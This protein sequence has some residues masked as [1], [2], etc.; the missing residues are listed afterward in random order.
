MAQ[1]QQNWSHSTAS[2]SLTVGGN[3]PPQV[4][5]NAQ[6]QSQPQQSQVTQQQQMAVSSAT[7][8]FGLPSS[9]FHSAAGGKP[10]STQPPGQHPGQ[11]GFRMSNNGLVDMPMQRS[12][13]EA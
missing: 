10:V 11:N 13:F 9:V 5:M 7:G 8:P 3:G 6:P 2:T 12:E 4:P 1:A